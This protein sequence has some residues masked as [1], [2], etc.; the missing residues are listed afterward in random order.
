MATAC[1]LLSTL[2]PQY[3]RFPL[4]IK[5]DPESRPR[6]GTPVAR[7]ATLALAVRFAARTHIICFGIALPLRVPVGRVSRLCYSTAAAAPCVGAVILEALVEE[8]IQALR[9]LGSKRSAVPPQQVAVISFSRSTLPCYVGT[10][11]P[12][13]VPDINSNAFLPKRALVLAILCSSRPSSYVGDIPTRACLA[14]V[15]APADVG[16][17][18]GRYLTRVTEG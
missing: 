9:A 12:G 6:P 14:Y 18:R 17:R 16:V 2:F 1:Q 8:G 13:H 3:P 7:T 15:T 10:I 5:R 11:V 4:Y